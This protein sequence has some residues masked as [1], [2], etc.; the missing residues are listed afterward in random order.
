MDLSKS[1]YHVAK[2]AFRMLQNDECGFTEEEE[3]IV[4]RSKQ[5]IL[6]IKSGGT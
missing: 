5:T 1:L 6:L 2:S 4:Q 3:Q